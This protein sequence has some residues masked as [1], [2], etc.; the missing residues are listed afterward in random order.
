MNFTK[1]LR[2]PFFYRRHPVAASKIWKIVK[3]I[4]LKILFY[5]SYW[6]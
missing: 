2:T 6:K 1:F 4:A 5:R 3:P